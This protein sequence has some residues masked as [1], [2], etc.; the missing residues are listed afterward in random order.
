MSIITPAG[1][2]GNIY[3]LK[4]IKMISIEVNGKVVT[5]MN[6]VLDM[7]FRE[8]KDTKKIDS[9]NMDI[10]FLNTVR[11]LEDVGL[12]KKSMSLIFPFCNYYTLESEELLD[13]MIRCFERVN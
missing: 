9:T 12:V 2:N 4:E 5:A 8:L 7:L 6:A 13:Y 1:N 10:I 11:E 3:E